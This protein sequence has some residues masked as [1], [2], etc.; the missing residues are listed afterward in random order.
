MTEKIEVSEIPFAAKY[1][2]FVSPQIEFSGDLEGRRFRE[3]AIIEVPQ[4]LYLL[5]GPREDGGLTHLAVDVCSDFFARH[6]DWE[7]EVTATLDGTVVDKRLFHGWYH[8]HQFL[9][10]IPYFRQKMQRLELHAQ[11]TRI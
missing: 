7:Y 3:T 8:R 9:L 4:L 1:L 6:Q 5:Y 11:P 10:E 2:G